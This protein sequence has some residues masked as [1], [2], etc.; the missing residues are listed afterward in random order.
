[1]ISDN[2]FFLKMNSQLRVAQLSFNPSYIQITYQNS[3]K[4]IHESV[5]LTASVEFSGSAHSFYFYH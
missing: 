4:F 3:C 1:M 2:H 5:V